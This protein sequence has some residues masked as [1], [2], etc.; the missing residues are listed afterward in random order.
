LKSYNVND[1]RKARFF[2]P[3]PA[4][5]TNPILRT[6]RMTYDGSTTLFV[7]P[8]TDEIY[9]IRAECYA[10]KGQKNQAMDDLNTLLRNRWT[11]GTWTDLQAI[12][13]NDALTKIL[14]ER[15][16]ELCFR[17]IRW[18]DLRRLNMEPQFATTLTKLLNNQLV[19]LPSNSL[20]YVFPIPPN[21]IELTG[22]QQNQR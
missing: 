5:T 11:S 19:N 20:L 10:R 21:V 18:T 8:A 3:Q 2:K 16:R 6:I 7:G 14:A 22:M 13:A 15:R 12:D 17:S 1:L 9:L 4:N